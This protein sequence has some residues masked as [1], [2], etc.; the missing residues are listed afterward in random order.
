MTAI[1]PALFEVLEEL[2]REW[3]EVEVYHKRGRSRMLRVT[4]HGE[5]L[6][7]RQEE[8][9]AVRAGD[10]RSSF[11]YAG[12]G[13][14]HAATAWPSG[15]GEGLRLPSAKPSL[16]WH[17]SPTFETPP[18]SE[19]EAREVFAALER[20][21]EN[22]M[23]GARLLHGDL[24]DGQS[25]S[26]LVSSRG[27]EMRVPHRAASLV[28]EAVGP[29]KR[30]SVITSLAGR[31]AT[32][33]PVAGLARRLA[34]RLE[35]LERGKALIRD[36]GEILMAP[37]VMASLL[38]AMV[39]LW[40][41]PK[42]VERIHPLIDRRGRI[43]SPMLTLIDNGRL[44][45]GVL[46]TPLDGEGQSTREMVL[47]EHGMY[48]QPL[49]AWWQ[50]LK[51]PGKVSGCVRRV[52]W[53]DLPVPGPTHLHLRPDPETSVGE[54]LSG[55]PRGFYLLDTEGPARLDPE[56]L[57]FAVPVCGFAIEGGRS[58]GSI[59]GTYLVGSVGTL[60]Q[61]LLAVARDLTFLPMAGGMI[62]SPTVLVKSL[63]LRR[64]P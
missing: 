14:P 64:R 57:R 22:E 6:G 19:S 7:F 60:L 30:T 10:E 41:G 51:E 61:G 17:P 25:E 4:P 23:P 3:S 39:D 43:G 55:L 13:L 52:S 31:Q 59:T 54:L 27:I 8:G 21:L 36:R 50:A 28:L 58:T 29:R 2:R 5:V 32:N 34:D 11:F 20:E 40:V 18:A 44:P 15:D 26:F 47:V 12:E 42:A 49:L 62:G 46:E 24:E 33:F 56:S 38:A 9:W 63:E 37:P 35:I 1:H 45:G 16:P 53:R 48:R